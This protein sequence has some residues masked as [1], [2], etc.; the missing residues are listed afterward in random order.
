MVAFCLL[1]TNLI[2]AQ[3]HP[4]IPVLPNERPNLINPV[5]GKDIVINFQPSENQQA[6]AICSAPNG[7]LYAAYSHNAPDDYH[8]LTIMKSEDNGINWSV[9]FQG[10]VGLWWSIVSKIELVAGGTDESNYKVWFAYIMHDTI[11]DI[12]LPGVSRINGITGVLEAGMYND[13][14]NKYSDISLATDMGFPSQG[15]D[16]FSIAFL[17]SKSDSYYFDTLYLLTSSNGGLSFDAVQVVDAVGYPGSTTIRDVDLSYGYS[18]SNSTGGYYA[19]WEREDKLNTDIH[20]IY[21]AH[22]VSGFNGP[23]TPPVRLDTIDPTYADHSTNPVIACQSGNNDNDSMN[24][25]SVVLFEQFVPVQ[26]SNKIS[27]CF[28]LQAASTSYFQPFSVSSLTDNLIEPDICYNPYNNNFLATYFDSESKSLPVVSQQMNFQAPSTWNVITGKYNEETTLSAP[29]PKISISH[30]EEC[31]IN[32][33]ISEIYPEYGS[34]LFDSQNSTYTGNMDQDPSIF[35]PSFQFFPNPCDDILTVR[36]KSDRTIMISVT[37]MDISGKQIS[38]MEN[39]PISTGVSDIKVDLSIFHPGSY[40]LR[41]QGVDF[42]DS[43]III[44]R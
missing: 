9:L 17:Y 31:A 22:T 24:I 43:Q 36:A 12:Y 29:M 30:S 40:L 10:D 1:F 39:H 42:S 13:D 41:V 16:P 23:L 21:S 18:P 6:A 28:N 38:L 33:W 15:A 19:V 2:N 3:S 44:R 25:T 8:T 7:W 37:L 14:F 26:N 11:Q 27:G 35:T 20:R 32:V 34:V 5:F 4:Q